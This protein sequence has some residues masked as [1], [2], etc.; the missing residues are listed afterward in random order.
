MSQVY[1]LT[2]AFRL[3]DKTTDFWALALKIWNKMQINSWLKP[4]SAVFLIPSIN[5]GVKG[6]FAT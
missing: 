5:A 1:L 2:P 4:S 3:G 6:Y